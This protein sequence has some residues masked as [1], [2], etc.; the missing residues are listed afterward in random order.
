MWW[1]KPLLIPLQKIK[2][3]QSTKQ[4]KHEHLKVKKINPSAINY[5]KVDHWINQVDWINHGLLKEPKHK[6]Q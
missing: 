2:L 1:S 3:T 6:T 5:T 4:K